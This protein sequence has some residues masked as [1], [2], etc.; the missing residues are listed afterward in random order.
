[1]RVAEELLRS[2]AGGEIILY[3]VEY[4]DLES[5][6]MDEKYS[7]GI[8]LTLLEAEEAAKTC[9]IEMLD[10]YD[11]DYDAD[12][13]RDRSSESKTPPWSLKI[14]DLFVQNKNNEA[15]KLFETTYRQTFRINKHT[16]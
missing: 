3:Q 14:R 16:V 11:A 8:Y 12:F 1:V 9:I 2:G 13:G 15:R 7:C 4:E 6:R 5:F 10:N